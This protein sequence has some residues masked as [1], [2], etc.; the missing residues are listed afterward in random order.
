MSNLWVGLVWWSETSPNEAV[1]FKARGF[2]AYNTYQR[3]MEFDNN[4]GQAHSHALSS[5]GVRN[6]LC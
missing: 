5:P 4:G 2:P 1:Y 6:E 3:A